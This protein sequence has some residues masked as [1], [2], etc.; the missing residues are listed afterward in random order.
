MLSY[1]LIIA[2]LPLFPRFLQFPG[3]NLKQPPLPLQE[4][5]QEELLAINNNSQ[6]AK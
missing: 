5:E 2:Q 3:C 4:G 6:V 1:L